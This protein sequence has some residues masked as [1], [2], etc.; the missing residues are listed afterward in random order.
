MGVFQS[1]VRLQFHE[2]RLQYSEKEQI[3]QWQAARP[4]ERIVELDVPL[5]YG[6]FD[7]DHHQTMVTIFEIYQPPQ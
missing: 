7:V 3:I 4:G 2:R 1:V 5:S 6:L